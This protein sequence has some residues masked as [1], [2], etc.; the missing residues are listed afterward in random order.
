MAKQRLD[1]YLQ[2]NEFTLDDV[3]FP[4]RKIPDFEVSDVDLTSN[5]TKRIKLKMPL[6]SSPMDT[7]TGAGMAILMALQGGIGTIHLNQTIEDQMAEVERVRR[8]E[9]GF[10]T[11]PKVLAKDATVGVVYQ[12]AEENGFWSYPITED[13][14]L[15]TRMV[16]IITHRD[17]RFL[18]D[19]S[20]GISEVMTPLEKVISIKVSK[21]NGLTDIKPANQLL[22]KH[23][24]DTLPVVDGG[25]KI[26][27]L[28]T[29]SD[30]SK[31]E[32]YPLA[33]KDKNHQLKV[34]VAVE[35]RLTSARDRIIAARDAGASGII[36]DSRNI[37]VDHLEIA[38]FTKKHAPQL[39][40]ILGNVV[41][42]DVIRQV[43]KEIGKYIDA[44]RIGM[45]TG[46][47]CTTT[48]SLGLGRAMGSAL[49]DICDELI[50][51]GNGHIGII[52][53]GGIK[54]PAHIVGAL[55][56]GATTIMMGSWLAGFDE[57][58]ASMVD[59]EDGGIG[60][61]VRGMGSLSALAQRAGAS[62]YNVSQASLQDRYP[63][64]IEKVIPYVGPGERKIRDLYNGVRQAM[65][66][67]GHKNIADLQKNGFMRHYIRAA[68][69]G[70]L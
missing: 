7:V 69:K 37:F 15:N 44:F 30:L 20:Q 32:A 2:T 6:V 9:A 22:R 13:G 19:M 61:R 38:K 35:S 18:E 39:D 28:V 27:A 62:R 34:L 25:F 55:I 42:A 31:N 8:F 48:E 10:V 65:H 11:T 54:S 41:E 45:G 67:L 12:E 68:S 29:D 17:V 5:L 57:S 23:N 70:T 21:T 4:P 40:V 47:V 64:G 58:A 59:R 66:G 46:E 36:V 3:I 14:T 51:N 53:D 24:I 52:A 56:L 43:I 50:K 49:R 1:P 16:G 60:K 26:V 33:T 63:E